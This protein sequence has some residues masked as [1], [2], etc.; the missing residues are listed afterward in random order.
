MKI[1]LEN[2]KALVGGSTQGLGKA[3]A[4]QMAHCGASVTLLA[5]NEEKLISVL[6]EL[7][8]EFGQK[9]NY[10][11]AD[12]SELDNFKDIV[13][14]Y[15]KSNPIDILVNN[16]NGPAS[17]NIFEKNNSDYQAAFN[18]LFQTVCFT[19]LEALPNMQKNNFGRII[20]V[21]SMT[22]KEPIQHLVLSNTIRTAL[23]SWAKTL[24][25]EVASS[26]ITVNNLVTGYFATER[27]N[28]LIDS[29]AKNLNI[30]FDE[31]KTRLEEQIPMKRLGKPEEYGYL[32]A[33]LASDYASYITGTNIPIDGGFIK[34]I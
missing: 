1:S 30:E 28:H 23:I 17:G 15:L 31:Y 13:S 26:N 2:K 29:Q 33:F 6:N 3:I 9:H 34:S 18:L 20:N 11:V 10:L 5:R 27:L 24:A 14:T 25:V 8:T 16:T 7:P 21:S 12:F 4:L 19:T 32:A 22:V